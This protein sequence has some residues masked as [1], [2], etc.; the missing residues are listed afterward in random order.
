[1]NMFYKNKV[2]EEKIRVLCRFF[3][4]FLLDYE[5]VIVYVYVYVCQKDSG[6]GGNDFWVGII[7]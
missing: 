7:K 5:K 1:M 3:G 6:F 2:R 4:I